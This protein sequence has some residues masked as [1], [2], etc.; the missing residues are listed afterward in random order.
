[1]FQDETLKNHLEQS[2]TIKSRSAVIAEWNMNLT[3]NIFKIGNYRYR[4]LDQTIPKYSSLINN[5]DEYDEG[6]FYTNATDADIV[7]NGGT[8]DEENVPVLFKAKKAKE[9]LLYSLE[10]CFGRFRPRSGINKLRY[11]PGN[12]THYSHP[13]MSS[14]PRYYMA[15][16]EDP[17]KYWTSYR[18]ESTYRY[19]LPYNALPKT[20]VYG[21][22]PTYIDETGVERAGELFSSTE[23]GIA[24]QELGSSQTYKIDDAAP[25]IVYKDPVPANRIIVKMQT[26]VGTINLG[27]YS[28]ASE[29]F[30]DPFFGEQ[31]QTTPV[32]WRVQY[33]SEDS[34][35]DAKIFDSNSV[36]SNGAPV[37]R[38][39][40]YVELSY[41][42]VIP[43]EF[44]LIFKK[45]KELS[46]TDFLPIDASIGDAYLVKSNPDD[47]GE[48][49]VFLGEN[50]EYASFTPRY[51]WFLSDDS[52]SSTSAF[53]TKLV[54]PDRYL[55]NASGRYYYSEFKEVLGLRLVIES[56]NRAGATFD[57]LELSPRLAIDL[58]DSVTSIS[59]QKIASD[60]GVAGLPV[61]QLLASTGSMSIFDS[62][63]AFNENN[64]FN[65]QLGTGSIVSKFISKNLQIKLYEIIENVVNINEGSGES[66]FADYYVPIKTMYSDGFPTVD[67]ANREVSLTLRDLYFYFE[68]LTAPQLLIQN[69]SVSYA[70]SLLL[71]SIGFSNYTFKRAE[72]EKENVIP[73]FFV[74][75]D[76]SIAQVLNDIAVSTQTAMFFDEYN[77]FVLMSK[78]YMLPTND[79][80]PT[81][82]VLR[83][84]K[85]F[86]DSGI[87]ENKQG[88]L[89]NSVHVDTPGL[90]NILGISSQT[91]S[92]YND[93]VVNYTQRSIRKT[94]GSLQQQ[95]LRSQDQ[96]WI[97]EPSLLW[98]VTASENLGS[99]N[100][101][102]GNQPEYILSAIPLNT[103]LSD[104]VPTVKNFKVVDNVIDL[105]EAIYSVSRY[106]GYYYSGGEVVRYDAI[107]YSIPGISQI[108]PNNPNIENNNVWITNIKEYQDY[109]SK[110][111]F[112]G[113]IY[114][115]GLIRI[116]TEP[117]Y[118][119]VIDPITKE[120]FTRLKNGPVAKHGR[121]QFGTG[122][123]SHSAGLPA[124]WSSNENV[125]GCEMNSKLLF[126]DIPE[127]TSFAS[128]V[129]SNSNKTF[130]VDTLKN[131]VVGALVSLRAED[132]T[133]TTGVRSSSVVS[134]DQANKTFTV[135]DTLNI[136]NGDAIVIENLIKTQQNVAAGI[137]NTIAQASTR[138][139]IIR[140]QLSTVYK[141]EA[142]VNSLF[143]TEP[144]TIQSS[145]FVLTGPPPSV[146]Y[147]P[148]DFISYVFKPLSNRFKHFGTRVRI[149]GRSE[150][151]EIRN[152]T[153]LGSTTYYSPQPTAPGSEV[154]ISG[155]SGGMGIFVNPLT[156]N[157]YYYEIIA[158][159]QES[160]G[161]Y[162][163]ASS[164]HNI[165]FY[166]IEKDQFSNKATPVKL[167]G[168]YDSQI[169]TDPGDLTGQYRLAGDDFSS[170]YDLAVEYEEIGNSLRFYLY[171]D[172]R[173][174]GVVDDNNKLQIH[175]NMALFTRG[176]SRCMFENIYAITN[177]YG[178]NL[179][180][181]LNASVSSVF[182]NDEVTVSESFK[183]YSVSGI[184]K[185]SYLSGISSES[186]PK[187][188]MYLEEFG[189]IMREAAYFNVK[190]DKA[191]PAL[192]AKIMPTFNKIRGYT[193]SGFMAGAYGAEFLVFNA[194]DTV[195]SLDSS[196]SNYLVI[197]GIAFTQ[198]SQDEY[199]VDDY[200]ESRSNFSKPKLVDN[201]RVISP[202]VSQEEYFDIKNSRTAYGRNE[203][204]L[205]AKYIQTQDDAKDLMGWMVK[206]IMKPRKSLGVEIFAIPTLQL[207]DIV[208]VDYKDSS[209]I[210]VATT[211][212]SR[213]VVYNIEYGKTEAGPT[214]TVYLSEVV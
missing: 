131:I 20:Y 32:R 72:G 3:E 116:Y 54:S 181:A 138:N 100:N 121:G 41:G 110:I 133:S 153:A 136:I 18:S 211:D 154:V 23:R 84:S 48:Y 47:L 200:F 113:K 102:T 204:S 66:F 174:V 45:Q 145:A 115:T 208:E 79:Q 93:G 165:I 213:F 189:T 95:E 44:Q 114:P 59:M 205:D 98:E 52:I 38:P 28:T 139:G 141:T 58:T 14:R 37:I 50:Q 75:P 212:T 71:D 46:S 103:N 144:G 203:F 30:E 143:S 81:D 184:I 169:I 192:Y 132:G 53:V 33:L 130:K 77:N 134:L 209:G 5:F 210:S 125:R 56:M 137:S 17:F 31:N 112:N 149:I 39:D 97:Y 123:V 87:L 202:A 155:A 207:G 86:Y 6:Y 171:L 119:N 117:N 73:Y 57:L 173:V 99:A 167:W 166:K 177:S 19:Q 101:K 163:N 22:S 88:K 65:S 90:A 7:V 162:E 78:D 70:V 42:L 105:G 9:A 197:Q 128:F 151:S 67:S 182:D 8:S 168:T 190:Y 21:S 170:V 35:L 160:L 64:V 40:G 140:S 36:R 175:N 186:P 118:E 156:N 109:F 25:Y 201:S 96:T 129:A 164:I 82:F 61:S 126:S 89:V 193:V 55:D 83:G 147:A 199:S 91:N 68:S 195:L 27:P 176:S 60:L 183:K 188:D 16:K 106:S 107:Q 196:Q 11:F 194:T 80:R 142:E 111:P 135:G 122:V 152:Q 74:P 10:D 92:V 108:D 206:K 24:T 161:D 12:F 172:G 179:G 49:Y 13:E 124:Y 127:T 63:Q 104:V 69:A 15:S 191:F 214:M 94:F 157:G 180:S 148:L 62:E 85:D 34:W 187:F 159:N 158:L 29:T 4:P 51:D 76:T 1:M 185:N 146:N 43:E 198:E 26:G 150:N 2:A 178:E 120:S